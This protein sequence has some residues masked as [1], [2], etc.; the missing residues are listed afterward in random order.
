MALA[1][2][3]NSAAMLGRS[4]NSSGG[5]GF[6]DRILTNL[7]NVSPEAWQ[8]LASGLAQKGTFAQGLAGGLTNMHQ[9]IEQQRKKKS[10]ADALGGIS[11]EF[12]PQQQQ[13]VGALDPEQ[14]VP[15]IAQKLFKQQAEWAQVDQNGD[16]KPDA[17]RNTQTGEIKSVPEGGGPFGSGFMGQA[18]NIIAAAQAD[19]RLRMTPEY[20]LAVDIYKTMQLIPSPTGE[21]VPFQRNLPD[22]FATP[23][24]PPQP[25]ASP[26]APPQVAPAP[27]GP[28]APMTFAP[29]PGESIGAPITPSPVVP[30]SAYSVGAPV[31]G[32]GSKPNEQQMKAQNFYVRMAASDQTL[33][34]PDKIGRF[35]DSTNAAPREMGLGFL[36]SGPAQQ[37]QQSGDEWISAMLRYDSGAAVPPS[38][39]TQYRATFI[40]AW[41][42][43]PEK[44]QQKAQARA[45]LNEA[46]KSGL[47]PKQALDAAGIVLAHPNPGTSEGW[48]IEQVK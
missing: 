36:Q 40:P 20:K 32:T 31:V 41:G 11:S 26:T 28:P 16:G 34:D 25:Q 7:Q 48:K 23:G 44:I 39:L 2:A 8:S 6:F 17:Q 4:A 27:A 1:D 33:N 9:T 12:T 42:D 19:P 10:L 22:G 43:K 45:R 14:A 38:E 5:S 21:M 35:V 37:M 46:T 24:A 15:F 18:A 29:R 13:F 30:G 3:L 47:T